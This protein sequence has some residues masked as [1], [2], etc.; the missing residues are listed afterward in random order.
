MRGLQALPLPGPQDVRR[1]RVVFKR[2]NV[3]GVKSKKMGDKS[4]LGTALT[5]EEVADLNRS[6]PEIAFVG[7]SNVGKSSLINA[8]LC[9]SKHNRAVV[10]KKPG[11][12][13]T[14]NAYA[15][16]HNSHSRHRKVASHALVAVDLPGYGYA[17]AS[18]EVVQDMTDIIRDYVLYR[19]AYPNFLRAFLLVDARRGLSESD[20]SMMEMFDANAV[21]YQ[22]VLTKCDAVSAPNLETTAERISEELGQPHHSASLPLLMGVSS[23]SNTGI[24]ALRSEIMRAIGEAQDS[25]RLLAMID[26]KR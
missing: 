21:L 22:V 15:I 20:L 14:L 26:K 24:Q 11:R 4:Y 5:A 13:K 16:G 8:L 18:F 17:K 19:S 9:L 3:H 25:E 7:R 1:A 2:D 6:A 10:S 23:K 12:T